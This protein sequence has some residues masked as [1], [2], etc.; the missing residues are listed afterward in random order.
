[1]RCRQVPGIFFI[2]GLKLKTEETKTALKSVS[3]LVSFS[4]SMLIL[5]PT[6]GILLSLFAASSADE[7]VSSRSLA[8]L[9]REQHSRI[10]RPARHRAELSLPPRGNGLHERTHARKCKR[11][12]HTH[13]PG[14][15][16]SDFQLRQSTVR[17]PSCPPSFQGSGPESRS[18]GSGVKVRVQVGSGS[19]SL[20]GF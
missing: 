20:S 2:H 19:E 11:I 18:A 10:H 3:A 8:G 4:S 7:L 15:Q 6:V 12:L 9:G 17:S 5:L 14:H 16:I 13:G 1:M